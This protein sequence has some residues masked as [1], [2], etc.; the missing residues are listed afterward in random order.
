MVLN[1]SWTGSDRHHIKGRVLEA[2]WA[3]CALLEQAESPIAK[4]FPRIVILLGDAKEAAE[5]I[6]N[7]SDDEINLRPE[8]WRKKSGHGIRQ[9]PSTAKSSNGLAMLI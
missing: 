1:T 2:G 9:N 8:G 5:I 7:A 6:K 4:W 3:G